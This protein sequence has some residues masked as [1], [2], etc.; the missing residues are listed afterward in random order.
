M[1]IALEEPLPETASERPL[2]DPAGPVGPSARS[3]FPCGRT[4]ERTP[5][6][7]YTLIAGPFAAR[8]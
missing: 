2:P 6:R 7:E 1:L 3:G 4:P 8:V 5:A